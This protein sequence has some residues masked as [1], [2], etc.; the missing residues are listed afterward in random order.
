MA[1]K[2]IDSPT[3]NDCASCRLI[4]GFSLLLCSAYVFSAVKRYNT[5]FAKISS[6]LFG[7]SLGYTGIARLLNMYPFE[8]HSNLKEKKNANF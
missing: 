4:G 2:N 7:I 6:G 1:D 5:K 3:K 8:T